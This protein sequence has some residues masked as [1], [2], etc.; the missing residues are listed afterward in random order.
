MFK[1]LAFLT[2]FAVFM[3][4]VTHAACSHAN[5]LRCLDSVCA[6]NLSTNPAARC[7]YCGTA[8]AGEPESGGMK[9][10]SVGGSTRYN[11][12]EREL[13]K[14]PTDPGERYVWATNQCISRVAGCT[15]DDVSETYDKLIEQSCTA[16]GISAQM[17]TLS[18][19]LT[20]T[21]T[22]ATCTSE[23]TACIQTNTKCHTDFTG[24]QSDS[25]FTRFFSECIA[26]VTGCDEH[27]TNLRSELLSMRATAEK[28]ASLVLTSIVQAYQSDR[29]KR[30]A[31]AKS[32]CINN[33]GRESCINLV[34]NQRMPNK[35]ADGFSDEISMATSLCK[36]YD[37]ACATLK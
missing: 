26:T 24:C 37:T 23:I 17:E 34:C 14:A 4:T 7:Q 21:K 28:N 6:I 25:E 9:N 8:N 10:V 19:K 3:P 22:R 12:T 30:L 20:K 33:S 11:L 13:K 36:F 1:K 16:A 35:C 2:V 29:A 5:L 32:T 31:H 15:P 27:T 18:G